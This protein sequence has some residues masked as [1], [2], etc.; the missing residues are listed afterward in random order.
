MR[1]L[2]AAILVA[3]LLGALSLNASAAGCKK[4]YTYDSE[5]GKCVKVPKGSHR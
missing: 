1:V 5:Q 4:G 2:T 3:G